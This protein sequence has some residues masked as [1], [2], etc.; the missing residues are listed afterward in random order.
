ME[1]KL[2]TYEMEER[3]LFTAANP[4]KRKITEEQIHKFEGYTAEILTGMGMDINTPST[5][6][7]PRRYIQALSKRPK[8][9][10]ATPNCSRPLPPNASAIRIAV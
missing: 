4:K 3:D 9:T 1:F 8:G 7:T 10:T 5:Q 2:D 6:E